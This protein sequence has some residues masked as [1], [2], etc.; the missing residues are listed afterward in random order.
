MITDL[1]VPAF[2]AGVYCSLL[3][4]MCESEI[5]PGERRKIVNFHN[6]FRAS[7]IPSASNM[8]KMVA[9]TIVALTRL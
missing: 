4:M 5:T 3:M 8:E 2:V 1:F 7:V 9:T 6:N